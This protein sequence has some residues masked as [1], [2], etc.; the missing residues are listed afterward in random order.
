MLERLIN[1]CIAGQ[2]DRGMIPPEER[3]AYE[4]G[5]FLLAL[6]I[7][8]ISVMALIGI[9]SHCFFPLLFFTLCLIALRKYAGGIHASTYI[10]CAAASAILE[11]FVVFLLRS[12]L[13]QTLFLPAIPLALCGCVII[14][15]FSPVAASKKP[16]SAEETS[17]FRQ[18]SRRR[19]TAE[20]T[21][22]VLLFFF[23]FHL[24][25]FVTMLDFIVIG[26]A[27]GMVAI[28]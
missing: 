28:N 20:L 16:L 2:I 19:L 13:W 1:R 4:Y 27:M 12:G 6:E 24:L 22:A 9:L 18:K 14:W 25:A 3:E 17:L 10:R 5:Y 8:N 7:L 11:L 23:Q 26:A 21:L 15:R